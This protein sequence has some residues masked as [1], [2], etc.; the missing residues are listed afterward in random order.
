MLMENIIITKGR[1]TDTISLK[2]SMPHFFVHLDQ[3]HVA[4][5]LDRNKLI[6]TR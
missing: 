4:V 1:Y 3:A 5:N 2:F 6:E